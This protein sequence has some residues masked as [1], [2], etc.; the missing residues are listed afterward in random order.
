MRRAALILLLSGFLLTT[1]LS[2]AKVADPARR[3]HM[4]VTMSGNPVGEYV[5]GLEADG[6]FRSKT[7]L[8]L[9][10]MKIDSQ[11]QGQFDKDGRLLAYT[12]THEA[13]D[14]KVRLALKEGK[15]TVTM[16]DGTAK[17]LPY[18]AAIQTYHGD[19]HPELAGSLL[20]AADFAKKQAQPIKAFVLDAGAVLEPKVTPLDERTVRAGKVRQYRVE[21]SGTTVQY[22]MTETGRV[23]A[24]DV[25]GQQLRLVADGWDDLFTDPFARYPELSQPTFKVKPPS[26]QRLRTRDGVELVQDV[27]LP[28]GTGPFPVILARTP[29]GRGTEL[30]HAEMYVRRGYAFVAQD[31]RGRN[32][33]AGEWDPFVH[34]IKDGHDT[35]DWIVKQSW[36]DGNIGM[37]GASYVGFVQWAAAASHHPALKCIIPQVSPPASAMHNLPYDYGTF[38]LLG[39]LKWGNIV[40]DRKANMS[41]GLPHPKKFDT[42]P[43]SKT[44]D[45]V[46]GQD[47]PFYDRWL[48]RTTSADWKGWNF[49]DEFPK[50][51]IPALHISGWWDGDEIGTNLNWEALR[52][53]R[54]TNQ[55]L[56]YGPWEHNFN[57]TTKFG[58]FDYGDTAI[59]DLD[60]LYVRWFDTWLKR[61][62]VGLERIP[63][64]QAFLS[65]ANRWVSGADWPLPAARERSFY[66]SAD[67][68]A[69]GANSQ[70]RLVATPPGQQAPSV[71]TYDPA[72]DEIAPEILKPDP[73]KSATRLDD[74]LVREDVLI[75][76]TE[77]LARPLAIAG[78]YEVELH[79]QCS[80]A[81]T[82]F[83]V[84][85][86][87]IDEKGSMQLFGLPGKIRASYLGGFDRQVP[88]SPDRSYLVRIKPWDSAHELKAGHRLGLV[89]SSSM[90]PAYARN[91]GTVE[92]IKDAVQMV[93]QRNTILHDARHPSRLKLHA[94]SE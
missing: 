5:Y 48:E 7:T 45:A 10:A 12:M 56:I 72:R 83:F 93:K 82:D 2:L 34:E 91:L 23:V 37:I 3:T 21:F 89:L 9:G 88:L 24:M 39:N 4:T 78:P 60:T 30:L 29:Y 13:G 57:A 35:L 38:L 61:K 54:R 18:D 52:A 50:I 70:G 80:A 66:F 75:F 43:L 49:Y 17:D 79:F 58:D 65:G 68:P 67:G 53:A 81:D 31:C 32:D 55:W 86:A 74:W 42:L 22:S 8:A 44:D 36:C 51:T 14:E 27:L 76:K 41:A 47:L 63:R 33:S 77:P 73:A 62:D 64:V 71:Y 40:R 6:T 94:L 69:T 16:P 85:L 11:L 19:L 90:F 25:P 28:E 59:I 20:R 26:T 1:H 92:P 84:M 46:L 87:D 15:L